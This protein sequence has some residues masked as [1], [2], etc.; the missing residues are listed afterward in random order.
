VNLATCL[1][2]ANRRT[3]LVDL[4]NQGNATS[5]LGHEHSADR[6]GA[7]EVLLGSVRA[8]NAI[9]GTDVPGLDLVPA[10]RELAGIDIDLFN[11]TRQPQ[12]ALR[13]AGLGELG[14]DYVIIDT[15]PSLGMVP[16]NALTA[17]D[18]CLIPQQ[19]EYLAL[20]G[21]GAMLQTVEK[22]RQSL[23]PRLAID[24]VVLTMFDARVKLHHEVARNVREHLGELVFEQI[25]PQNIRLAEAPSFGQPVLLYDIGCRGAQGYIQLA[26]QYLARVEGTEPPRAEVRH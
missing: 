12:F 9:L 3:L 18:A 22:V 16:I 26:A 23:N 17:A 7:P 13:D 15:P 8:A 4:D 14:Y 1:A 11:Q 24:G 2:L 25:I 21:L 19:T 6:P 10:S 5:S 20:E